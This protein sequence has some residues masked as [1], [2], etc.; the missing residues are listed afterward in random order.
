MFSI[1]Y[2][3]RR[4]LLKRTQR[5]IPRRVEPSDV[6]VKCGEGIPENSRRIS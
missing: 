2:E 1:S 4:A 3:Q 6:F 5:L